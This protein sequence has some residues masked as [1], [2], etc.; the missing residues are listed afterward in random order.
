M[1]IER[2]IWI[3]SSFIS[4]ILTAVLFMLW[5]AMNEF[6]RAADQLPDDPAVQAFLDREAFEPDYTVRTGV[7]VQSIEFDGATDVQVSGYIWQHY[8]DGVH[9]AIKPGPDEVG[10]IMPE[11]VDASDGEIY[12]AYRYDVRDGEVIGWYFEQKLR[13]EFNYT[14]Y[15]FDHKTVWIR[16]WPRDFTTKIALVPDFE[17]Y[18]ATGTGPDNI[19]GI[20]QNIIMGTWERENTYFDYDLSELETDLGTGVIRSGRPELRYNMVVKR[21]FENAF[22]VHMV[23]LF[24]VAMLLFGAVMTV[25][26]NQTLIE[27]HDFSTS[28]VVGTCS[29]LFFVV[30]LAH[31]QLREGFAGSP[32]IYMEYFYFLMYFLLLGVSVNTYL[33]ASESMPSLRVIHWHDNLIPKAAFWPAVLLFM[34]AITAYS[35]RV[36]T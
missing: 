34:V 19:F 33:F 20:D 32:I 9:D 13:Q 15:P 28:T 10:I 30:L 14:S 8:V 6:E 3:G 7:F 12:E 25:T 17:A 31:V 29:V 24:V 36:Q 11:R 26:R 18:Q 16:L 21:K 2:W 27:R 35:L 23:P 4:F 22:I 5:S 1:S